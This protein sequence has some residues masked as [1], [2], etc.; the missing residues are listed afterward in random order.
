[1]SDFKGAKIKPATRRT[2]K[3]MESPPRG[4]ILFN[5][6]TLLAA[7]VELYST[8]T[9]FAI[10]GGGALSVEWCDSFKALLDDVDITAP[11]DVDSL[12]D[13]VTAISVWGALKK[14][15]TIA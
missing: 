14:G 13:A 3:H 11:S 4:A 8:N 5:T 1:M 6:E 15:T 10:L 9:G 12:F 2:M 7:G